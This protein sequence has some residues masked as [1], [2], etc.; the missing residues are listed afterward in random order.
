MIIEDFFNGSVNLDRYVLRPLSHLKQTWD[1]S[2]DK[3][4]KRFVVEKDSFGTDFNELITELEHTNPPD[5]YHDNEDKIAEY[6]KKF[7][8]WE[9]QKINRRW[10]GADYEFILEQGGF[11]DIDEKNL[12]LAASGRIH[13]AIKFGQDHFD[14][15]EDGHMNILSNILSIILFHRYNLQE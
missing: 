14:D 4:T 1:L 10:T 5:N 8:K 15:M 9:I 6:F 3:S 2:W 12:V 7:L 13:A 11:G